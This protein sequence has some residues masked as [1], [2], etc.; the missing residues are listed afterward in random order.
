M[1]WH[2]PFEQ[3]NYSFSALRINFVALDRQRF[4]ATV[5]LKTSIKNKR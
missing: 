5:L 4:K 1:V 3:A 2:F